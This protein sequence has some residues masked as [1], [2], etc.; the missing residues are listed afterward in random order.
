MVNKAEVVSALQTLF[1]GAPEEGRRTNLSEFRTDHA[2]HL[3]LGDI[4]DADAS[5]Q[6]K[7][8]LL[9]G[10]Q[11]AQGEMTVILIDHKSRGEFMLELAGESELDPRTG[12]ELIVSGTPGGHTTICVRPSMKL[13]IDSPSFL[14]FVELMQARSEDVALRDAAALIDLTGKALG[15][16]KK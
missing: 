13:L 3:S 10:F 16:A 8:L 15:L 4:L 11:R 9:L 5:E 7:T 6:L 12:A 2:T 14:S 1:S